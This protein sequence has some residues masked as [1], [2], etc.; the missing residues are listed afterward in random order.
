MA[1]KKP[2]VQYDLKEGRFSAQ[3]ASLYAVNTDPA[4][5][6]KKILYLIDNPEIS[7]EMGEFGFKRVTNELSWTFEGAKLKEFYNRVFDEK[8]VKKDAHL[9]P[10]PRLND[11]DPVNETLANRIVHE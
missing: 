6:A 2:I 7:R 10:H 5:F 9:M 11:P 8:R 1:L 3:K 4:D